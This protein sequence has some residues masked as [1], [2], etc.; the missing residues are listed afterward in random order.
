M[1]NITTVLRYNADFS[2]AI[3]QSRALAAQIGILSTAFNHLDK[4]ATQARN[5]MATA[6][7]TQ[8]AGIGGFTSKMVD[9]TGQTERFGKALAANKL[10][11]REYFN[12]AY[13]GYTRQ[14]SLMRKL[15]RQQV[16]F[17]ESIVAPVGKDP[18]GRMQARVIT[19]ATVDFKNAS[20]RM[21]LMS[22]EFAIFNQLVRNGADELINMG[23]NTQWTGR[24]LTVGLTMPVV[25]FGAMFA[26]T[27]M[28]IDKQMTR[29]AKVYG[30]DVSGTVLEETN[31]MKEAVMGLASEISS[32]YGV[33]AKETVGLAADIAATGKEGQDLLNTVEQTNKLAVLGEVDRQEAMKATLAIQTAFKQNTEELADSINFLNAVENQTSTTLND[34]VEA[35]PKAGPVVKGLGGS[36]QDLSVLMVA[37]KEGGIPA[38]EAANA[39]KSGLAS[40]INPTKKA[41]EVAKQFGVDLVGIVNANKGQLMPTIMAVQDALSGLDSFSRSRVIEEIFG[42]YQFARISALFNNLGKAGSQTQQAMELAGASTTDLAAIANQELA[43]YTEST[44]VRFQRMVETIKN[45]LI[46]LAGALL[47]SIIPVLDKVSSIIDFLKQGFDKI[48]NFIKEPMKIMGALALI[49]GPVLM[50]VGLF[51]NLIGNAIKFGMSIIGFGAKLRGIDTSKFELLNEESMA[52]KIKIDDVSNSFDRQ[53][54]A[55]Q[56]LNVELTKYLDALRK[57]AIANPQMIAGPAPA[58]AMGMRRRSS[59]SRGPETVPGGYGGGDKIPALLEPGEMVIRKEAVAKYQPIL[60]AMNAGTLQGFARST[61][62]QTVGQATGKKKNVGVHG[63]HTTMPFAI[64]TPQHATGM[65]FAAERF[66]PDFI[67]F[68]NLFG[69]VEGAIQVLSKSVAL[70]PSSLNLKL[71]TGASIEDFREG[72]NR[73]GPS[74]YAA[75]AVGGGF[76]LKEE[77]ANAALERFEKAVRDESIRLAKE[78]KE[79]KVTDEILAKAQANVIAKSKNL[80]SSTDA[81]DVAYR[82]LARAVAIQAARVGAVTLSATPQ[83]MAAYPQ[84]FGKDDKGNLMF[85]KD[86][87]N[88]TLLVKTSETSESRGGTRARGIREKVPA[89]LAGGYD[90]VTDERR[91]TAARLG[92]NP[93]LLGPLGTLTAAPSMKIGTAVPPMTRGSGGGGYLGAESALKVLQTARRDAVRLGDMAAVQFI[94]GLIESFRSTLGIKSP[95]KR[96]RDAARREGKNSAEGFALGAQEGFEEA[97]DRLAKIGL[98]EGREAASSL[99][100]GIQRGMGEIAAKKAAAQAGLQQA[101]QQRMRLETSLASAQARLANMGPGF[102]ATPI[103]AAT[104]K[105]IEIYEKQILAL[106]QQELRDEKYI[107]SLN[108]AESKLAQ[109]KLELEKQIIQLTEVERQQAA[110]A[111]AMPNQIGAPGVAGG[112]VS[113]DAG[114]GRGMGGAMNAMFGL[115]MV[116]STMTMFGDQTSAATSALSQFSMAL[117]AVSSLMMFMPSGGGFF[118]KR[119]IDPATGLKRQRNILG[120]TGLG[121]GMLARSGRYQPDLK[122]GGLLK[123]LQGNR[124][125][126]PAGA[127]GGGAM[128]M[129]GEFA[130]AIGTKGGPYVAAAVIAIAAVTAA[131]IQYNRAAEE[132]R[133]RTVAAFSDPMKTAEALGSKI[134]TA[135]DLQK[136]LNQQYRTRMA[137]STDPIDP[138]L[139]EAVRQ[140]YAMLIEKIKYQSAEAGAQELAQAYNKML[141]AGL[142]A[143]KAK[144][145]VRAI[146][147]EAGAAGGAAFST[148]V[149][150]N[151][152]AADNLKEAIQSTVDSMNPAKNLELK[153]QLGQ[154]KAAAEAVQGDMFGQALN[155]VNFI[156]MVGPAITFFKNIGGNIAE[157]GFFSGF[158]E[159]MQQASPL[160]AIGAALAQANWLPDQLYFAFSDDVEALQEQSQRVDQFKKDIEEMSDVSTTQLVAMSEQ[161]TQAFDKAPIEAKRAFRKIAEF[162]QQYNAVAFD[163]KP[164]EDYLNAI[165]GVV[166]PVLTQFIQ[167]DPDPAEQQRRASVIMHAVT[168]GVPVDEINRIVSTHINDLRTMERLIKTLSRHYGLLEKAVNLLEERKQSIINFASGPLTAAL[169]VGQDALEDLLQA[170][171]DYVDSREK[172]KETLE[173]AFKERQDLIDDEIESLEDEK[174]QIE[175]TTDAYVKSIEK[176]KKADSFYLQQRKS[177]LSA[178][179]K[180]AQGDIFGFIMERQEKAGKAAEYS[181]DREIEKIE[182]RKDAELQAIDDVIKA[183]QKEKELNDENHQ[184][185]MDNYD[186]VTEAGKRAYETRIQNQRTHNAEMTTLIDQLNN[187]EVATVQEVTAQFGIELGKR[188]EERQKHVARAMVLESRQLIFTGQ[189]TVQKEA[190]RLVEFGKAMYGGRKFEEMF[191]SRVGR[192]ERGAIDVA[193]AFLRSLGVDSITKS[194]VEFKGY[195]S[196][197]DQKFAGFPLLVNGKPV[198]GTNPMPVKIVD[199]QFK[200]VIDPDTAGTGGYFDFQEPLPQE[201]PLGEEYDEFQRNRLKPPYDRPEGEMVTHLNNVWR[202]T[203][204]DWVW[205][206]RAAMGGYIT[207][208]G[209]GIS[210]SIPAMLS[211]G[212]YVIRASSV[213]KY[214]VG[215]MDALNSGKIDGLAMGGM[216]KMKKLYLAG[217]GFAAGSMMSYK[218]GGPAPTSVRIDSR[219]RYNIYINGVSTENAKDIANMVMKKIHQEKMRMNHERYING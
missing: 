174:E 151:L 89:Y 180:L 206:R 105:Q 142:S 80:A 64:G 194:P 47:E 120:L 214:G 125:T 73:A 2:S 33:A 153:R 44:T 196:A 54:I 207:G 143:E 81:V 34:L 189:S 152:M 217:G 201:S 5:A 12:E 144:E 46:P 86:P 146:A 183:K 72:W 148:A 29:F 21:K 39:I 118:G 30:Q 169:K 70:L 161:M 77:G 56:K 51:K 63:G 205:I 11:M 192:P 82:K 215:F 45:Q 49:A 100:S 133:K 199:G 190:A 104:R 115:S 102:A 216:P 62:G 179:S 79:K 156:P 167:L 171:Q 210:D 88:R 209:S 176:R 132:A 135:T 165:D 159:T 103:G 95:S 76:D 97:S 98:Q 138:T 26:K 52:A 208:P 25:L 117:M 55:I 145:A 22:Q 59:G 211:N 90:T 13:R 9:L 40:L 17:Q 92:I 48:P 110:Q 170:Q 123:D 35:I 204:E 91:T 116:M 129:L 14:D 8:A 32:K 106:K 122:S 1:D 137:G 42:K 155:P 121:E 78:T 66:G 212:E 83:M 177:S 28:D 50:L 188:Y 10:T 203:G 68:Y 136:E 111:A 187:G 141:S 75:T 173:D 93:A 158:V 112:M 84:Y 31:R 114:P 126:G 23:K 219:D 37:M 130:F 60:G 197:Q 178:L 166:G 3:A 134:R 147:A 119:P 113:P 18:S 200:F 108:A 24:Q 43:A 149:S 16:K 94:D 65:V 27:F 69:R 15:A 131:I 36:I 85:G 160:N 101:Q 139:L 164:I 7:A 20:T 4:S 74:K 198:A 213:D 38:A 58:R 154:Q 6:F 184:I 157:K 182:E 218:D 172:D 127:K 140:D 181:Y 71:R 195:V 109:K 87:K 191:P 175:R 107:N 185:M 99:V 168:S 128:A 186:D 41:S 162:A 163:I 57:T 150:K 61:G 67:D 202:S 96:L 193:D 19:P 53:K 124:I